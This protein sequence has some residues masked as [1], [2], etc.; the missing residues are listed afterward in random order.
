MDKRYIIS[1]VLTMVGLLLMVGAVGS[2][3]CDQISIGQAL[4]RGIIGG[5]LTF[6]AVIIGEE[7]A[8]DD[9]HRK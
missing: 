5:V 7:R 6:V 2:L 8:E 9:A 3:E 4:V 1:A